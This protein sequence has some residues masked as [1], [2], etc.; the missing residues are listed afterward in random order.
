MI[1]RNKVLSIVKLKGPVLPMEVAKE[2]GSD[3]I[4]TGAVL[5]EL[6]DKKLIKISS[7][8]IGGS[9]VYYA[10][11]QE[12]RLHRLYNYLNEKD[13]RA[14]DLLKQ[15]KIINDS[16]ADPLLRVALRSIKD[17]A[18]ALE[19]NMDGEKIIF[20]KWYLLSGADAERIIREKLGIRQAEPEERKTEEPKESKKEPEQRKAQREERK[21]EKKE[22]LPEKKEEQKKLE[23]EDTD[24]GGHEL[25][26]DVKKVFREK[27]IE[28][29]ET[30]VI[31][32]NSDIEMTIKVPSQV[33]RLTYFC[34]I[35]NKKKS[36]DKD[37]SSVYV[38]G[39]VKKL[40]VLYVT[41]GELTKKALEKLENEF[42]M[43]SVL[44]LKNG[45]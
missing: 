21:E 32:K 13:R 5:S 8:K 44:Y 28:V 41:T 4:F 29:L 24:E 15:Q 23:K 40:P 2:V 42:K 43:I 20:W 16:E 12:E 17:F 11:G 38:D 26:A 9:P 22:T 19:V 1:D 36:N 7:A 33:G 3:T 34:K 18:K 37:L 14:Y 10:E 31:R 39:Q 30:A 6:L 45:N 35:R 25:L 27:G